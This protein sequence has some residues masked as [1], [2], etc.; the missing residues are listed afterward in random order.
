MT[1]GI[2][3]HE[4]TLAQAL[5]SRGYDTMCIGKWHLG[6]H[7]E[8]LPTRHGF[9]HYFG[10]PYSNDMNR[11]KS[12]EPPI[13]L[14]RDETIVEQPAAQDTLT[15]R[16]TEEAV[17]FIKDHAAGAAKNGPSFS[18]FPTR[19]RTFPCTPALL[20]AVRVLGAFTVT[21]SRSLTAARA[22]SCRLFAT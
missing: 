7:S 10:I 6:H 18:I 9:N 14:L 15:P 13:P 17:K 4:I 1:G 12:N 22:R 19:F 16:Y 20:I 3:D 2:P 8:F 21:L 11:A 5:K